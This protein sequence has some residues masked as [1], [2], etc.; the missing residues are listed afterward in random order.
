[1]LES[2]MLLAVP[3]AAARTASHA[4]RLPMPPKTL[5]ETGLEPRLVV[6]LV[7]KAIAQ[8]GKVHVPVL[9]SL[10]R[11]P[12]SVLRE[13]LGAMQADGLVD[14]A[15]RG[16]TDLDVQY[17]LTAAGR[18]HAAAAL[19]ACRYCGPAPVTLEAY[20][21][22][23]QRQSLRELPEYRIGAADMHD[24][25]AGACLPDGVRDVIGAAMHAGRSLLLYGAPGSGKSTLARKLGRLQK[26]V[27]A[28]P[29]ALVVGSRIVQLFDPAIHIVPSCLHVRLHGERRSVDSRWALCQRP[30]VMIDA[31]L[32][33][34]A[35]EM[36]R[37]DTNGVMHAPAH[38][39]ANGGMLVIDDL[40]R[41]RIDAGAIL[42]RLACASES[43]FDQLAV[44]GGNK[45]QLPFDVMTVYATN[46]D[47]GTLLDKAQLR[48]IDYKVHIGPLPEGLYRQ[49]FRQQCHALGIAF[50]E[51]VLDYLVGCLHRRS[52]RPMLA[53]HPREL[54]A[55]MTELASY[56]GTA[57]RLSTA[58][59]DQVWASMFAAPI[60]VE[61]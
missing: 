3:G 34:S 1:M 46:L 32:D 49:L 38:I 53:C 51:T 15:W 23:L 5:L 33:A 14:T 47:P 16:E 24:A 25:F 60:P 12:V 21:E 11:L 57:P 13:V 17:Q 36:R 8:R 2:E 4:P 31:Q 19:A 26:G 59:L 27:I 22:M 28:V 10:L 44:D 45:L 37:D 39:Q 50:D 43:R 52:G 42:N 54:L 55:R 7:A 18:Q 30:L 9:G 6:D 35:M 41:Q 40:G 29:Y 58:A 56:A 20:A 48:R 61:D